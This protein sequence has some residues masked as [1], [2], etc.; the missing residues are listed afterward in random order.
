MKVT[1]LGK[2]ELA[3]ENLKVLVSKEILV[4]LA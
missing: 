1:S 2:D 3:N 4:P